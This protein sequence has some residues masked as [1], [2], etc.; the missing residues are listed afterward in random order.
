M[1]IANSW[2]KKNGTAKK[3]TF[4][5]DNCKTAIDF[6]MVRKS[7]RSLVTDVNVINT[8]AFIPQH[9]LLI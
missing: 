6:I 4:E 3:I 1:I 7:K 8:K 5:K 9:K 2:F